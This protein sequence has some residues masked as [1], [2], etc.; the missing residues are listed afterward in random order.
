MK[1]LKSYM[2]ASKNSF[3]ANKKLMGKYCKKI[4]KLMNF[5]K[6]LIKMKKLHMN[7]TKKLTN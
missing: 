3:N 4:L 2:K 5:R 1:L 7:K 6:K